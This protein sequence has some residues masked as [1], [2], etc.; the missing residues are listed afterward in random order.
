MHVNANQL[1]I[2][3]Y[4]FT[5]V[6]AKNLREFFIFA[7]ALKSYLKMH[8]ACVFYWVSL[9]QN[10]SQYESWYHFQWL[11]R[12]KYFFVRIW[13]IAV[14]LHVTVYASTK[15]VFTNSSLFYQLRSRQP[16]TADPLWKSWTF[17]GI[18]ALFLN[19]ILHRMI[20]PQVVRDWYFL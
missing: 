14:A 5:H 15:T 6:F 12:F 11:K 17:S 2:H 3:G 16:K 18:L 19:N 1:Q 9:C 20:W 10:R 7:Y 13:L 8:Q 4:G